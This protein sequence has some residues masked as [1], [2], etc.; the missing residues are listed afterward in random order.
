MGTIQLSFIIPLYNTEAYV[1]RCLQSVVNQ[2]FGPDEFEVI[3]VD[4]GSTDGGKDVVQSFAAAHPQVR[5]IC[6]QNAGVSAARNVAIDAAR[7]HYVQFVDSDDYLQEGLM[8]PLLRRAVDESL[9]V[10]EFNY[11]CKDA[12]GRPIP[13]VRDDNYPSTA[14]MTGVDYLGDHCM[15]PY[16]WRFL[17]RRDFLLQGGW[18]FNTS[19]IVCEDGALIA[20]FM[21]NAARVAHDAT[22]PYCYVNRGDSAMHNPD[23]DHLKRRIYSQIDAAVSIDKSMQAY[24]AS[25]GKEAP[26]SVAGVRNVYLYFSMTKA[27][28]CGLVDEVVDCI[29]QA[30]LFPFPCVGPEANYYGAKWKAIHRLMMHPRLWTFLSR[31]YRMI[32]K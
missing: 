13:H 2:G 10:L 31:I 28:T 5:L 17:I 24:Q 6:Q 27:L 32:K 23:R 16:V 9:D 8:Q 19:L 25:S 4:D 30:G 18:R 26:L 11:E 21:L 1:L 7:G 12:E 3:V 29:R 22:A 14:V 15:T 20:D